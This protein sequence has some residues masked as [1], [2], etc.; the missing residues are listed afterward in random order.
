MTTTI[1]FA[2]T[3]DAYLISSDASYSAALT[4]PADSVSSVSDTSLFVGQQKS[5]LIYTIWQAF[6]EFGFTPRRTACRP[7]P[8][9]A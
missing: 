3:N 8:T 2:N 7:R 9:S 6:L 1:A 5:G 4:G